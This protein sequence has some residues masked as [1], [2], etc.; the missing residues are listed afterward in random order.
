MSMIT[1]ETG[2]LPICVDCQ[3]KHAVDLKAHT[4]PGTERR[5]KVAEIVE[6]IRKDLAM[7]KDQLREFEEIRE[8]EHRIED[9]LTVL[10]DMRHDLQAQTVPEEMKENP[11]NPETLEGCSFEKKVF[12]AKEHFDPGSFRTLCPECPEGRCALC[13]PELRCATRVVIG[14]PTGQFTEGRCQVGTEAHV[15]YHGASKPS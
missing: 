2:N 11:G 14:C 7:R 13:P 8:I 3:V 5:E 4:E 12:Q 10:R 1:L 6:D 9:Y 15:I